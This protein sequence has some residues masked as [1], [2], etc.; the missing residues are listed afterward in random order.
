M[1]TAQDQMI[2]RVFPPA[3]WPSPPEEMT[4]STLLEIEACPR[5]WALSS[6]NYPRIWAGRGYPPQIQVSSIAGSVIH[7]ALD[8]IVI[9]LVRAGCL[10]LQDV[11]A[12]QVMRNL[13]GYTSLVN[14]CID[15]V[16][17]RFVKN[18]RAARQY[19]YAVRRL[20][21]QLPELRMRIQTLLGR[22]RLPATTVFTA[23][24]GGAGQRRPLFNGVY[25]EV[26]LLAKQI[27]WK[28]KADLLVLSGEACEIIDF[29]TG[30]RNE[31]HASQIRIYALLWSR[32]AGLNPSQR[33]A[34][35]LMLTYTKGNVT[36]PAPSS[37]ELDALERELV[38]RRDLAKGAVEKEPPQ[39][40]PSTESCR[41]CGVRQL[42]DEYWTAETQN[43]LRGA[44]NDEEFADIE[45]TITGRHGPSS[46]DG[47]VSVSKNLKPG[48]GVLLRTASE[49]EFNFGCGDRI[50][51]LNAH[52]S[53]GR[54]DQAEPAII[55]GGTLSEVFKIGSPLGTGDYL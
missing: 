5:R 25:P 48:S 22:V 45:I 35:R 36:V 53:V 27:A 11:R 3:A 24:P 33:L 9:E 49:E 21:A 40:K 4:V 7:L 29:K 2:W 38:T 17:G 1:L 51:V 26:E 12:A 10:S 54:Q 34:N 47:L 31:R 52:S 6:A 39:A 13:G 46:W 23:R 28:G 50:R 55:T 19:D 44:S 8:T 30:D 14:V 15:R 41:E 42:C 32:D 18:P 43:L 16:T 20:R 37:A